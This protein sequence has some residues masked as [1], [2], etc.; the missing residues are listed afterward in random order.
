MDI[1]DIYHFLDKAVQ[2]NASD[3]HL[4]AGARPT[5]RIDGE[6]VSLEDYVLKPEDTRR[7]A[8]QIL[9]DEQASLFAERGE[10]DFSYGNA[11]LGSFRVNI[12]RQRGSTGLAMRVVSKLIPSLDSL[13]LPETVSTLA[14][15]SQ[16]LILVTGPAGSGKSTTIAAM[17]D[18]I[19]EE[20]ACHIVTLE[21]PIEYLHTNKK[22]IINQREIGRDSRSFPG[23]LRAALRQDP[24]VI[25]VGEMR[26]LETISIAITAAETG[27]LVLATLHTASAPQT[28]ER[29]ID[30]FPPNQQQQVR[31]QLSSTLAGVI[32]QR[33]L[34]RKGGGGRLAALEILIS[35]LAVR[36]LIRERKLH[37]IYSAM[38]TGGRFG[39][40]TMDKALQELY[41]NMLIDAD[42]VRRYAADLEVVE[43]FLQQSDNG[44]DR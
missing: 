43:R 4:T 38:Q 6:L 17:I 33:L 7:L 11:E 1:I 30:A 44:Q 12:Y 24:D 22:S 10:L 27:H 3:L 19:N 37:Q 26:D 21:D 20:R 2:R 18:L 32:S 16:G 8:G 40:Q 15:R 28:V 41:K 13:G 34:R 31:I 35:T 29:I 5:L 9:T 36:N 25:M 39:M 14:R 42:E 23:A